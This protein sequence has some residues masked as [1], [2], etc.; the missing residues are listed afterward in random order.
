M[1]TLRGLRRCRRSI[2]PEHSPSAV[3]NAPSDIHRSQIR[4]RPVTPPGP[5]FDWNV[6]SARMY[7][8]RQQTVRIDAHTLVEEHAALRQQRLQAPVAERIERFRR[9]ADKFAADEH[10]RNRLAAATL[11]QHGA[12]LS[13]TVVA[14]IRGRI[15]VDGSIRNLALGEQLAH[16]PTEFAPFE[17]E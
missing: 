6:S 1:H 3:I 10:L 5:W 2:S 7:P 17:R 4:Q 8:A 11:A 13:A 9:A 14:L 16:S 12:N 15:K